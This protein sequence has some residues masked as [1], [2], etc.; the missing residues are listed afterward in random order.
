MAGLR[1]MDDLVRG[2]GGGGGGVPRVGRSAD[3]SVDPS[4][5]AVATGCFIR[6]PASRGAAR[7]DLWRPVPAQTASAPRTQPSPCYILPLDIPVQT[8]MGRR[9][10][11]TQGEKETRL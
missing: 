1:L 8:D 5:A 7:R 3:G 11:R 2:G 6:R 10:A 4:S 9:D